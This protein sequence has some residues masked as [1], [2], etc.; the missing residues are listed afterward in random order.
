MF[1]RLRGLVPGARVRSIAPGVCAILLALHVAPV[2]TR[3]D[4]QSAQSADQAG[5]SSI[6]LS[7]VQMSTAELMAMEAA[8]SGA[9]TSAADG[10]VADLTVGT[11]FTAAT[12]QEVSATPPDGHVAAGPTQVVVVTNGRFRSFTKSTSAAD[13]MLNLSPNSFFSLVRSGGSTFGARVRFDSSTNRWFVTMATDATPGRVVMAVSNGATITGST[14]WNFSAFDNT[15]NSNT[16]KIDG[17]T[18]GVDA[19]ALY[20][21]VNQFCGSG[22]AY[23]GTSAF[24]V[25]KSTTFTGSAPV[26]TRFDNLTGTP[27]GAGLFSPRGVDSAD[28]S[29]ASGYFIGVDNSAFGRLVLRRVSNPGG[30]PT[31]SGDI[32]LDVAA[33]AA[34]VPVRHLGNTGGTAGY[35]APGDDRLSSATLRGGR[36][37]TAHAIGVDGSGGAGALRNGVRWYEIGSVDSSPA[38]LQSGT[39][40]SPGSGGVD[41]RNYWNPS[42]AITGQNRSVIGFSTA[43]SAEYV[44]AGVT[45]RLNTDAANTF[46]T[47]ALYTAASSAYNVTSNTDTAQGRRWG[48][49]SGTVT[50]ACDDTTVW[51]IQQYTNAADSYALQVAKV[52]IAGPPV[53][54]SASPSTVPH[55]RSSFDVTVTAGGSGAFFDSAAGFACRMSASISGVVVNQVTYVS[56]TSVVIN[57]STVNATPGAKAVTVINADLQSA[58]SS[59]A[60]LTVSE[61]SIPTMGIDTP[62][63]QGAVG[64]VFSITGWA[65]DRAAT[66]GTGVDGIH[67]YA[68]PRN[69]DGT[70]GSPTF[71]GVGTYGAA[72]SD[73]G[74]VFGSQY[75]N[76]GFSLTAS[77][78]SSG[79]YLIQV[80]LHS[81]VVG[82]FSGSQTI[83]VTAT[84]PVSTPVA[85]LDSP[86]AGSTLGQTF[87]VSG[88]ALDRGASSGTGVSGIHVYAFPLV[89]GVPQGGEFLGVASYGAARND[90]GAVY[91][92]QFTNCAFSFSATRPAGAYRIMAFAYST[93]ASAF[94]QAVYADIT[95]GDSP[96]SPVMAVD[97]PQRNTTVAQPFTLS[98]WAID[99]AATSGSGVTA[100]HVYAFPAGGGAP[101]FVG[102]GNYGAAR[103]D[104]A[105]YFGAQ[106]VNSGYSLSVSTL[107][108]GAYDF[109]VFAQSAV[110]GTFNQA[111]IVP[112]TVQ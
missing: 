47:P 33:T 58:T 46:G 4:A 81:A 105:G 41:E 18:L 5:E 73:I 101:T 79:V 57:V 92:S 38:V 76:S 82:A 88:W 39:I 11:N 84:G 43:G 69:G 86:A 80:F 103:G 40:Y 17:P 74:A 36:I 111:V 19:S 107:P 99:R 29:S 96:S 32:P 68:F 93:V 54:I 112:L 31:M 10:P 89:N 15:F 64:P 71:L 30:T 67:V 52:Q 108:P 60:I 94:N 20:L 75:T 90:V 2:V 13:G 1:E 70:L 37:W 25:R 14:I 23:T 109:Y 100:I 55:G 3:P 53:P 97:S 49:Y 59:G 28:G 16:C 44:N 22:S 8:S 104:L 34:P 6:G 51:T 56:Q 7:I 102:V 85:A 27:G 106:F 77:G 9:A 48:S 65:I 63:D 62:A 110:T 91:G 72:R 95:V 66:S 42:L 12:F 21:G 45:E 24:V 26:V 98:G 35:L 83:L 78:L 50:D 87:T 61:P